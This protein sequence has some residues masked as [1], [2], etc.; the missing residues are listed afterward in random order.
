MH[1]RAQRQISGQNKLGQD[2]PQ[3]PHYQKHRRG[4]KVFFRTSTFRGEK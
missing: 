1:C 2:T 4:Q 3:I